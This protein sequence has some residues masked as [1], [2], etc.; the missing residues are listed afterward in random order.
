MVSQGR[1]SGRCRRAVQHRGHVIA[2]AGARP[3]T[4]SKRLCGLV[5]VASRVSG[6]DQTSYSRPRDALA[7]QMSPRADYRGAA[8]RPGMGRAKET[9]EPDHPLVARRRYGFICVDPVL[10]LTPQQLE[11]RRRCPLSRV[12]V[13]HFLENADWTFDVDSVRARVVRRTLLILSISSI[14]TSYRQVVTT[15][16]SDGIEL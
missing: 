8:T 10:A 7:K 14:S 16:V 9:V 11:R 15:L 2:P 4:T 6:A 12:F 5:L 3:E 1:G 13:A